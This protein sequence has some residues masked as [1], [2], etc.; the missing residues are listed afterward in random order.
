V[1][2]D[3]RV[4]ILSLQHGTVRTLAGPLKSLQV[5]TGYGLNLVR[6]DVTLFPSI[7]TSVVT[8]NGAVV[9]RYSAPAHGLQAVT[10]LLAVGSGTRVDVGVVRVYR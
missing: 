2:S 7:L 8:V 5:R 9:Q 10:R 4:S 6:V 3:G 1:T